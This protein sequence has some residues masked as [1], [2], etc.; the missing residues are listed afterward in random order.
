MRET[1]SSCKH[2]LQH[3]CLGESKLFRVNCGHCTA[4]KPRS[5]RPGS[6][7]CGQFLPGPADTDAFATE[8]YLSKALL[9]RLLSLPLL[10]EIEELPFFARE[11][12][13]KT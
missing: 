7:A 2:F 6:K 4:V 3:Y 13:H 5:R 8:E 1:C 11:A 9:V 12:R 10:P